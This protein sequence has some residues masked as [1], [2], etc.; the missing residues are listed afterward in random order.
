MGHISSVGSLW[1]HST[2][3]RSL[4]FD[5]SGINSH[6]G[7][8]GGAASDIDAYEESHFA[9]APDMSKHNHLHPEELETTVLESIPPLATSTGLSGILLLHMVLIYNLHSARFLAPIYYDC[10][11]DISIH[12]YSFQVTLLQLCL[13]LWQQ[14]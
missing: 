9:L 5:Y 11:V 6:G 7:D 1:P 13:H 12:P 14:V 8:N 3:D 10:F 4:L 2:S